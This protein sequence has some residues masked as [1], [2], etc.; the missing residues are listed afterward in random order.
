MQDFEKL[1]VF[2]LGRHKDNDGL[3]LYD[4]KDLVTHAVCVGMT[5]SGKTGLCIGLLEE[6]AIDGIPA[7]VV[8]PKGDLS[9]LL[10]TF[11]SLAPSDF[12]AWV[13]TDEARTQGVDAKTFAAQQAA[14][15]KEGLAK[16][17]QDGARIQRLRDAADF[18]IYTPASSAGLQV[19]ILKSLSAPPETVRDDREVYR[20]L[21]SGVASSLLSM[22]GVD[23]D[24]LKS[25]EHILVSALLDKAWSAGADMDLAALIAQ[26]QQ[27]PVEKLGVMDVNTFFPPKDRFELA[28]QFNNLLASPGF[29][30]WLE[31]EPLEI[32]RLLWT[33]SGKPRISIFSIAHLS[34]AERMFFV[35]LLLNR[36]LS[37][38]RAQP[39][40]T[41]LR[42]LFYMDE[43]FGYFPPVAMPP[44]KKPML[45]LLKQAR[46]FGV[47]MV[48]ATQNPMDLDYKGLA[49]TGT[50]FVG[51]LQTQNDVDRLI[52]GPT[53]FDPAG[54]VGERD[55][56]RAPLVDRGLAI[57]VRA[58]VARD[59]HL[60][61][62][63]H[64]GGA[65]RPRAAIVAVED[66][67]RVF[68]HVPL[69]EGDHHPPDL[70]IHRRD[71]RGI[72]T[73]R[74]VADGPVSV[75]VFL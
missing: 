6:A 60:R 45:T 54:P 55:D 30:A 27:P 66:D 56:P 5:G 16:W 51:R 75:Q 14:L 24:P 33:S 67:Q 43:I 58:V 36:M 29:A 12:E 31:G 74:R 65:G 48:L 8:D 57:A 44:S 1:G 26:I 38:V 49:N 7:I 47:G 17:G 52:D 61:R 13:N 69:L 53:G 22:A 50:W 15:W 62:I 64:T 42:A 63:R 68:T 41:S 32:D 20:D 10:L 11:P 59:L 18:A 3:L 9:D 23:A 73:A 28:M 25:R 40:S 72:G 21:I 70:V 34:D 37:W 19:S 2:Y 35:S 46:A 39:G 4:S 71:H